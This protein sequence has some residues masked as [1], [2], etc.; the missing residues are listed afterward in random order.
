MVVSLTV[1][2]IFLLIALPN[3]KKFLEVG[4][5]IACKTELST[6]RSALEL[7]HV[8]YQEYPGSLKDIT[9]EGFVSKKSLNDPWGNEYEYR[10]EY[11][12]KKNTGYQLFSLGKDGIQDTEDDIQS[13][14]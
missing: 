11:K 2:G 6:I 4:K 1:M 12:N 8:K 10:V 3:I 5:E 13:E 7:W 9:Q 14:E